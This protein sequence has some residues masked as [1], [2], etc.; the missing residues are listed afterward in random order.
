MAKQRIRKQEEVLQTTVESIRHNEYYDMQ[1]VFDELYKK[2]SNNESFE[3][4][5][6][7]ILSEKNILLAYR[8]IKSNGGSVTPGT[9]KVIIPATHCQATFA[10]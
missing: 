3:S 1:N 6:P 2:A 4:L 10:A 9:D 7:I 5:I 8:N